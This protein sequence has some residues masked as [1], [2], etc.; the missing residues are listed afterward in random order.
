MPR[1][2]LSQSSS[3]TRTPSFKL[4]HRQ[5][6]ANKLLGRG[7][8][9]S[10]LVG[11]AR[12]GKTFLIVRAIVIR[13]IKAEETR[14][15]ILRFR[16]N[17][18]RAS[19]VLDTFPKVM[20]LCF[21]EVGWKEHRQD[22]Y[23]EIQNRSEI[24]TG[25]L[26][27]AERVEKILG[28]EYLTLFFNEC[29]QI[30]YS[31]VLVAL[32][33]LAQVHHAV[34]QKAFYDLNPT[35]KTH[36]T[37]LQFGEWKDPVTRNPLKHTDQYARMFINPEDNKENLSQEFLDSLDS[38]PEKQ[39]RRFYKG[40]YI[41]EIDGAMWTYESLERCRDETLVVEEVLARCVRVG[42]GI[43]PSGAKGSEDERSN[44]IGIIIAGI[45][46]RG[47][48]YVFDDWTVSEGPAFWSKHV[49]RAYRRYSA[50]FCVAEVNFGG[51]M[52]RHTIKST[53]GGKNIPVYV[54][55][56]SRGKVARAEP[57]ANLYDEGKVTHL[58]RL[59]LL[60]DQLCSFSTAGYMG[61][62]SPDRADA[63]VWI[64]SK[65][66]LSSVEETDIGMPVQAGAAARERS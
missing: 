35:G 17:A 62:K 63:L 9:H 34:K 2:A 4:T 6:E 11:G 13:A 32:T 43:D 33:R 50:D 55:T 39:R 27:E 38:L 54:V 58:T 7:Q 60:E 47:H 19:V 21:P 26:D 28:Q 5:D 45:D 14:H 61:D 40:E 25:G 20:R 46:A 29:S 30:P 41:D 51:E 64:L 52:V 65:L 10:L 56:A 18:I 42:I 22:G 3:L 59:T 37:N 15:A 48:A 8:R 1:A 57:I 44:E 49:L 23:F 53:E 36:W 12:S 24:W 31:S 66:M 16:Q